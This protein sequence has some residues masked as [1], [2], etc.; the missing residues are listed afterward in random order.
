MS[1]AGAGSKAQRTLAA[2]VSRQILQLEATNGG[3]PAPARR[4]YTRG[5]SGSFPKQGNPNIDTQN[6]I[7]LIIRT[8]TRVPLIL[9]NSQMYI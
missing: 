3:N 8:P 4:P 5:I 6:T 2:S 9:G 1:R 7:V